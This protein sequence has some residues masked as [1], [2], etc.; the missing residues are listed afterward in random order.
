MCERVRWG[1]LGVRTLS[2][3]NII[4]EN[5]VVFIHGTPNSKIY[6]VQF[7]G[8]VECDYS[9]TEFRECG[10]YTS[11]RGIASSDEC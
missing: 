11:N 6:S 7:M 9:T 10:E 5:G 2:W 1:L 3:H 8:L 4:I